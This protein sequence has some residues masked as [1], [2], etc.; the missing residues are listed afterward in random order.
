MKEDKVVK[1]ILRGVTVTRSRALLLGFTGCMQQWQ[2]LIVIKS[3]YHGQSVIF[4]HRT[5]CQRTRPL[6]QPYFGFDCRS[7]WEAS[8]LIIMD[9]SFRLKFRAPSTLSFTNY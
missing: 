8:P 9:V 6:G 3:N 1:T 2:V 4:W 7:I 5:L